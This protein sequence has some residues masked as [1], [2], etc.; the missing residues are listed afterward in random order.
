MNI[1]E[2]L[3]DEE[4]EVNGIDAVSIV[5]NPAIESNFLAL[6]DQEIKLAKVDEEKRI[7]MGAALIPNKPIFRKQGEEMFY[8][9]FSK[10]TVRRASE[11]FFMNGNQNNATL[12]HQMSIN[13]L[14]VVESW[15]VEGEQDKSRLYD[16][17]V[18]VGTWMISMKVE[19]DEVWNDYVKSGKVKGFS[20]EGYFADKA[21]IEKKDDIKSEMKAIMEDEAQY[22]LSNIKALIKKDNRTKEGKRLELETF[23]DYPAAVSNNAKRGIELNEKV[24]N[25]CATQVGKIRAQQLAKKEN[26]SKETLKRMYSYLSRAAEYYDEN[27]KEACGTI[28]YLLWGGKAGLRWSESKLKELG[29][30]NLASMMIN[31]DFAIIDDRLA[32]STR[33]K[34]EEMAA[35][36]GCEGFHIHEFENKE[37][38]MPCEKHEL[39]KPCYD[40]YEMIGV[41]IKNGRRVPNCVKMK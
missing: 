24:N 12:E 22:M 40:G 17:E 18:P 20:I 35:N 10:E 30:I 6:A 14:T 13:D 3:L 36:I 32:Y 16:L 28:S 5:E 27:D 23:N 41:K 11:L 7:L 21:K 31:D 34:A 19:N 26:I 1:V 9:Y 39:K 4:N 15:I 2:L 25:K 33:E 38:Y 29:E 37:W 8:V